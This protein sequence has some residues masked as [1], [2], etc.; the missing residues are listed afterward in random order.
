MTYAC[1]PTLF[2][3]VKCFMSHMIASNIYL[4]YAY[5]YLNSALCY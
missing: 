3:T 5:I 1:I 2:D 4:T